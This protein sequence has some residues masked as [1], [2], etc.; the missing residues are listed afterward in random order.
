MRGWKGQGMP[1]G[2]RAAGPLLSIESA[3]LQK[4][5]RCTFAMHM[6]GMCLI[7][8]PGERRGVKQLGGG[9]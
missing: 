5:Q 9:P 7:E 6:L 3:G 1:G 4:T 8:R 2:W